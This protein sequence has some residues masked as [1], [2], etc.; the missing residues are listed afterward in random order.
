MY[1][2]PF[3]HDDGSWFSSVLKE[4]LW[5]NFYEM[6]SLL[7]MMAVYDCLSP[8]T[9]LTS[10]FN[11]SQ[12]F[13]HDRHLSIYILVTS[14]PSV[15]IIWSPFV[16][17]MVSWLPSSKLWRHSDYLSRLLS[18]DFLPSM[19]VNSFLS[20]NDGYPVI[21]IAI[22]HGGFGDWF[23][24][25]D[26]SRCGVCRI[27]EMVSS[28]SDLCRCGALRSWSSKVRRKH[29]SLISQLAAKSKN[30]DYLTQMWK[31]T[32]FDDPIEPKVV[33]MYM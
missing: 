3:C 23:S 18:L 9:V 31:P 25:L 16:I 13:S 22:C 17:L 33:A 30:V 7:T 27:Y 1:A 32:E 26:L 15:V 19:I 4:V 20:S 28:P 11:L 5:V 14:L 12:W 29:A 2:N 21:I 10:W 6:A 24:G 8:F